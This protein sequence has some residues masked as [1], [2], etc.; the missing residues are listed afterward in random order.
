[1]RGWQAGDLLEDRERLK[2][3]ILEAAPA[4][5]KKVDINFENKV[6][7]VGYKTVPELAPAGTKVTVTTY[8]RCDDPIEEGWQLF[9]HIQHEGHDK[10]ENLDANGPLRE[11]KGNHQVLG[12]DRWE[13]GRSTPTS[14]RSRCPP[15]SAAPTRRSTSASGRGDAR[16][17]IISG[18]VTATTARSSQDQDG[19]RPE[20]GRAKARRDRHPSAL[21]D[22]ARRR[23][24][25]R[26]STTAAT[27]PRGGS[28]E[29]RPFCRRGVGA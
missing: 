26:D 1:V 7:V 22:Q 2:A 19:R 6:H 3:Q 14:R 17:R 13:R 21:S 28:R 12:P 11:L 8:W 24:E 25:D 9:T 16:L 15:T 27:K 5:A 20:G 18:R 10:P 29:H 23:R 4:D